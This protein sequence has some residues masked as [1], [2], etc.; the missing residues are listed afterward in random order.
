MDKNYLR[1]MTGFSLGILWSIGF[2][3][4]VELA[5]LIFV[6]SFLFSFKKV[7]MIFWFCMGI[8]IFIESAIAIITLNATGTDFLALILSGLGIYL[9]FSGPAVSSFISENTPDPVPEPEK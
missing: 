5:L 2:P 7:A 6:L 9:N 4:S 8:A 3:P 1:V